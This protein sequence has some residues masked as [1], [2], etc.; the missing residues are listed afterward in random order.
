MISIERAQTVDRTA[1]ESLLEANDLPTAGF[2][3]AAATAVV[4]RA[5]TGAGEI[6]GLAAIE[7]YGSVG[8]LRSVCV[9]PPLR[10]AG[11]GRRLVT[12]AEAIATD[13]GIGQL[14]LL[15]ETAGDWF[16]RLGYELVAR[17]AVPAQLL[18]SPEFTG[19]CP[20]NA[21]LLRKI[22]DR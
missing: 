7:P 14:Y 16:P 9:A 18:G 4:A 8:L 1:M 20:D 13:L 3:F 15:T 17:E 2:E 11:L 22:L 6:V 19:A 12:E 10:S 21:H 5:E